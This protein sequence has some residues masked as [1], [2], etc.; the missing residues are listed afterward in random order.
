MKRNES[1]HEARVRR[2]G[3]LELKRW[4]KSHLKTCNGEPNFGA[5]V[6][7]EKVQG[8]QGYCGYELDHGIEVSQVLEK[9]EEILNN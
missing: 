4:L 2:E 9:I 8:P 5:T 7:R 3:L 1:N 6:E